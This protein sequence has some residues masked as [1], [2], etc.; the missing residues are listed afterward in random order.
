[1]ARVGATI[2][3]ERVKRY[4]VLLMGIHRVEGRVELKAVVVIRLMQ[5]TRRVGKMY[6]LE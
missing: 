5:T 4:K 2:W 3:R 6:P 1:M